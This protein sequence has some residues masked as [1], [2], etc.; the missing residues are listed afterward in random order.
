MLQQ[1]RA[2]VLTLA[3]LLDEAKGEAIEARGELVQVRS[4]CAQAVGRARKEATASIRKALAREG[5]AHGE[6]IRAIAQQLNSLSAAGQ[7]AVDVVEQAAAELQRESEEIRA[8]MEQIIA[9]KVRGDER[10]EPSSLMDSE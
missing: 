7:I 8:K 5:Q 6:R 4:A 2:E 10:S 1:K 9:E 3:E